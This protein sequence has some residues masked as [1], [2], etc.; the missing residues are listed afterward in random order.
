M[1]VGHDEKSSSTSGVMKK[2]VRP[3]VLREFCQ[4]IVPPREVVKKGTQQNV[5]FIKVCMCLIANTLTRV[6]ICLMCSCWSTI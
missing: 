4:I 6:S 1:N 3:Y 2:D 5:L